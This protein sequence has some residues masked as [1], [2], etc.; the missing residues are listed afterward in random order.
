MQRA[1]RPKRFLMAVWEG[2][3]TLP[4]EMEVAR[5]LIARGHTVRVIGD[6]TVEPMARAAGCGFTPWVQ[7]PHR[8]NLDPSTDI[9]GD[10]RFKN[11]LQLFARAVDALLCGPAAQFAADTLAELDRHPADMVLADTVLTGAL[12]A[13][14]ARNLP[15]A[16][17]VPNIYICPAP[18]IP[19]IGVGFAQARG[20]LGRVRDHAI[21]A[22]MDRMWRR[23]IPAINNARM[24]LGL[25]P[26]TTIWEQNNLVDAVFVLTSPS[27]DF[28]ADRLPPN[29]RYVGAQIEDPSWADPWQPPWP[30]DNRRPLALVGLSST[31]QNQVPVLRRVIAGFE[32]L[33]ARGLVTVGPAIDPAVFSD[34]PANVVVIRSAPHGQVL[35]QTSVCVTHCGH[36]TTLKALA[37]GVPL[38]CIPMGRDQHDTAARVTASGAGI[39]LKPTATS[40]QIREAIR[41]VL[42]GPYRKAAEKLAAE[43]AEESRTVDV[44]RDIEAIA[45]GLGVQNAERA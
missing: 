1:N 31:F 16:A 36:G 40:A 17:L 13:A 39:R 38:V 26:V 8:E 24:G 11:P 18:G 14:E 22:V 37:H 23:G 15:R 30:S 43:M 45:L 42:A 41:T 4:P 32:G 7:A 12:M 34:A 2:G 20:P 33:D 35:K 29:V 9:I 19:P 3:G 6:P 21:G 5:K 10:W 25:A 44:A 27:F 28:K